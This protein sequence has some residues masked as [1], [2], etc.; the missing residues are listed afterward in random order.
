MK[1]Y[2]ESLKEYRVREP[3]KS[4]HYATLT[5]ALV[6]GGILFVQ[7]IAFA[8]PFR[9]YEPLEIVLIWVPLGVMALLGYC[10]ANIWIT[11]RYR[12]SWVYT[13][14]TLLAFIIM[15]ISLRFR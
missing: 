13:L 9:F 8:I 6:L 7:I 12:L 1:Q 5:A 3:E 4:R 10:I 15:G 2:I 11:T 14:C